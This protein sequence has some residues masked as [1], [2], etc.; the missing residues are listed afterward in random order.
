[1]REG[2]AMIAPAAAGTIMPR[3]EPVLG[4]IEFPPVLWRSENVLFR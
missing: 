4:M 1:M 2:M 3:T